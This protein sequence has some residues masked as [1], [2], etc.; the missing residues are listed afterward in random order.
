MR[1]S[2]L[3]VI[4]ALAGCAGCRKKERFS[5]VKIIGHAGSGLE[6]T[7]SPY[8]ENS[9]EAI[10]YAI[11]MQ[12]IDGVEVDVQLSASK[13]AWL[14]HD[15]KLDDDTNGKGCIASL[16]D[17]YLNGVRYT[18]AEKEAL[19]P[20]ASLV[21][22]WKERLLLLDMRTVNMCTLESVDQQDMIDAVRN[23]LPEELFT[24][25]VVVNREDWVHAFYAEG[26]KVYFNRS[27]YSAYLSGATLTE[28]A[29]LCIRNAEIDANGVQK[30]QQAGK[31]VI[32]FDVRSPKGIRKALRK[33]PD[34]LMT[35]NLKAA[36]IEKYP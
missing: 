30:V 17:D 12:G 33:H 6:S 36:I 21:F 26:W 20:L 34:Y 25:C 7:V 5:E 32:I 8:S 3:I 22:P 23:A 1:F 2:V 27:D 29:G 11:N 16:T 24:V 13:N 28:T 9:A 10:D 14:F 18:S 4:I 35:D 31:E 19:L 15:E